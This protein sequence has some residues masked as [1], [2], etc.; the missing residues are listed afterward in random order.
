ML[1]TF[2]KRPLTLFMIVF[3]VMLMGIFV[4]FRLPVDLFPK[5]DQ[6]V[7]TITTIYPGASPEE[8]EDQ[9]SRK[10]E[11]EMADL[12]NID[13]IN[14]TSMQNVS[15][16]MIQFNWGTDLNVAE[17]QIRS[18]LGTIMGDLPPTIQDPVVERVNPSDKP[19]VEMVLVG[20]QDIK[21]L[22]AIAEDQV[23]DEL[24]RVPGV[25]SVKIFG[26]QENQVQIALDQQKLTQLGI[27]IGQIQE[28]LMKDNLALAIGSVDEGK[29]SLTVKSD[30]KI[31]N[32]SEI[33]NLPIPNSQGIP[34]RLKDLGEISIESTGPDQASYYNQKNAVTIYIYKQSDANTI[35]V[36]S[37]VTDQ[38]KLLQKQMGDNELTVTNDSSEFISHSVKNLTKEG[39]IGAGLATLI[40]YFF[41]GEIAATLVIALAIPLSIITALLLMY[42]SGL[43]I[44]LVTLGAIT[45]SIGLMVD[46][47]VVVLQNIY[48]HFKEEGK[49]VFKAAIEGTKEVASPVFSS[50]MT[51]MIVFLPMLF[52]GGMAGQIFRP[53]ALTAIYGLFA[54][55]VVSFT[56]TPTIT[57]LLLSYA[58]TKPW[59][60]KKT[61]WSMLLDRAR[62]GIENVY[63]KSLVW[64]LKYRKTVFTLALV[65]LIGGAALIPMIGKEF[66][67]KM[68]AGEFTVL[69]EMAPNTRLEETE[70]AVSKI[71]QKVNKIESKE[72]TYVGVGFTQD[73]PDLEQS[74]KAFIQVKLM[75]RKERDQS[76]AAVM[77]SLRKELNYAGA[78]IKVQEKGFVVTSLFSA[79]PIY[80]S[81]KGENLQVLGDISSDLTDMIR[82]IPG[83]RDPGNSLSGKKMEYVLHFDKEKLK[84][85][86]LD[87][88]QV[89]RTIRLA[90]EGDTVGVMTTDT[91][92]VDIYL[93]YQDKQ[94]N[95]IDEVA[96]MMLP[97]KQGMIPLHNFIQI[98]RGSTPPNIYRENQLRMSFV[99]AG[100]YN[101]D[102]STVNTMIKEK[103]QNYKLP[104]GYT[105]E[106]GGETK[107][108][109]ES[110]GDLGV[111]LILAI[112]LIYMV[113][114]ATFESFK[115]P[116]IIMFTIPLTLLG[117]TASLVL[118]GRN[119]SVS[120]ILG[121]IMLS[122]IIVS[123][124]IVMIEFMKHLRDRGL[125]AY[126]AVLKAGTIRL[127][128]ILMTTATAILG[129]VPIAFGLGEGSEMNAPMATVVLG[130]L[131][132]GTLLTLFVLPA[133]YYTLEAKS[134]KKVRLLQEK[135]D[136]GM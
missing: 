119:L 22:T 52:V 97:T 16:V 84:S 31:E 45:L 69:V 123:N 23:K 129:N 94:L 81:I 124:G 92:D 71:L 28:V 40:I 73:N 104:R 67:P 2:L 41:L 21:E 122:G 59:M 130:G 6:P 66:M 4:T 56:F 93:S 65:S 132:V 125:D 77:E 72:S 44:N 87:V 53:L 37:K 7:V 75:D 114:V 135:V 10:V 47:A 100:I 106:F 98:E 54:S 90:M 49:P 95:T 88:L 120:S 62:S 43:T 133:L 109:A 117:I 63:R 14:S 55:L 110:F 103:L 126:Q 86:G 51:K 42:F 25:S 74:D 102:L 99:T 1:H 34:L 36:A 46:D 60:Q 39:M 134:K 82:E 78:K 15:R 50:T 108:M 112:V 128:P 80:F 107:D 57:A 105:I 115:H 101:S 17:N 70:K 12:E 18:K 64:T 118:F 111:A 11:E 24:Q 96:K 48:R 26:G 19:I 38:V 89:S 76:T 13:S 79:D 116:F 68:D 9:V 127:T 30:S 29:K 131:T 5:L 32:L 61:K 20:E 85:Y 3:M 83:V 113:M 33:E 136:I 35:E 27:H 58:Q 91:G 121:V 8:L